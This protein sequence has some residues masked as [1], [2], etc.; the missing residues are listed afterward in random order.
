VPLIYA[1]AIVVSGRRVG[2]LP[3]Y[4]QTL[5]RALAALGVD[6]KK[7]TGRRDR[8]VRSFDRSDDHYRQSWLRGAPGSDPGK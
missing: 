3:S 2:Y 8:Q 1:D 6:A 7:L 5:E 4:D